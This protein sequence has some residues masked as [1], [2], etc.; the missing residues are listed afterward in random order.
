MKSANV[1]CLFR[2]ISDTE[3]VCY[4][5]F[6]AMHTR[7]DIMLWGALLQTVLGGGL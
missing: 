2:K 3:T 6:A 1:N 4:G 5:R 7:F